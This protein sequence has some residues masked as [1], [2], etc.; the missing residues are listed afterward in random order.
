MAENGEEIIGFPKVQFLVVIKLSGAAQAEKHQHTALSMELKISDLG[1][2]L[3]RKVKKLKTRSKYRKF[4]FSEGHTF[5]CDQKRVIR[6]SYQKIGC[7]R[8]SRWAS[9]NLFYPLNQKSQI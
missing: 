5:L 3:S 2:Y 7:S 8:L 1:G 9:H 6:G 4:D